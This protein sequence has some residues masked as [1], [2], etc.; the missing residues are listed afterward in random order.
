MKTLNNAVP[1]SRW[2]VLAEALLGFILLP[3]LVIAAPPAPGDLFADGPVISDSFA[4]SSIQGGPWLVFVEGTDPRGDMQILWFEVTQLG[5]RNSTE[6]ITLRGQNRR[7]FSGYVAIHMPF[8]IFGWQTVRAEIRIKDA[9]GY[10]SEKRTHQVDVGIPTREA[11]PEKWRP[12]LANKLGDIYF[13]FERDRGDRM[14]SSWH[15]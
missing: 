2:R 4:V 8:R 7:G 15:D 3:A 5:G 11:L 12:A 13:E 14:R 6:I 9:D 10:Y 1:G